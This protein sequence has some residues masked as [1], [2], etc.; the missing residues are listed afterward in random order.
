MRELNKMLEN[1]IQVPRS[2]S[3]P[4][5]K[6]TSSKLSPQSFLDQI[7]ESGLDPDEEDLEILLSKYYG[8]KKDENEEDDFKYEY[9]LAEYEKEKSQLDEYI[10]YR[11]K[12]EQS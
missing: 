12:F 6:A 2:S 10:F 9:D 1:I 7:E 8:N 11:K 3:L 5:M 4:N